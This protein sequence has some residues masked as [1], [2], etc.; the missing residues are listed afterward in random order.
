VNPLADARRALLSATC[1]D[2]E[3]RAEAEFP[4]DLPVFGGH[5]PGRPLVTGVAYIAIAQAAYE[6]AMGVKIR[7]LAVERCK[8]KTPTVPGERLRLTATVTDLGAQLRIKATLTKPDGVTCELH[9]LLG[10]CGDRLLATES[11]PGRVA[12]H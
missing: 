1:T 11:R 12:D 3:L 6:Q 2:G 8:W 10:A 4:A 5:F 7:I 9:L